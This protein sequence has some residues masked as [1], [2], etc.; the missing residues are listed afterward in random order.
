MNVQWIEQDG[1]KILYT[2]YSHTQPQQIIQGIET[3]IQMVSTMTGGLRSL[4]NFEGS[5]VDSSVMQR[6]KESGVEVF[7]PI[8]EK[9]AIVGVKGIRHVLLQAYNKVTGAGQHQRLFDTVEEALAWLAA[10]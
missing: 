2:D 3:A 4:S 7:E 6:L 9:Q 8:I 5:V 1:K 10:D